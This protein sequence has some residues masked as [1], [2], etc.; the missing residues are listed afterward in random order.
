MSEP[1]IS[2]AGISSAGISSARISSARIS[3]AGISSVGI[4][5]AGRVGTALARLARDAGLDVVVAG[6]TDT[7]GIADA[8][9]ADVVILAI[10]LGKYRTLPADALAGKLVIDALNYWWELDGLRP[11]FS[12]PLTSTSEIVQA[13][14]NGSRT[15]KT[16]NHASVWELENLAR[17]AGHPDRRAL[18]VAADA[19]ADADYASSLVD[20]MGF[21]PV[22]AGPLAS[23]VMFEPGT[24]AFGADATAAE[25]RTMLNRF[26]TSQRGLVVARARD[27]AV[28]EW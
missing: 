11:E 24:E 7:Q 17:P 18:A 2:S 5:G 27:I 28:P 6:S 20:A 16:F 13:F 15:A 25:L 3:S 9:H 10:P 14:L 4:L 23:G 26:W 12:D 19:A 1:Q 21:D 22:P 8:T